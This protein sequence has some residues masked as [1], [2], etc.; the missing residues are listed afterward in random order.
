MSK[1]RLEGKVAIITGAAS[2]IG[3]ATARLFAENG[4]FVVIADIQDELGQSV[5]ASI[6][7]DKS[8]YRHCDVRDENQVEETVTF[9]LGK[10]G[11][12]DVLFSNAGIIGPPTSILDMNL[13][14]LDNTIAVNVRGVAATIK[15]VAR[16]M[17]QHKTR[18][19]II[20]TMSV[21]ANVGGTGPHAYSTS[22]SA[23]IGL[24]RSTASELGKDGI[25]VNGVSPHGVA[26]PLSCGVS[27]VEPS[28]LEA[29]CCSTSC[30]KGVVLKTGHVAEAVLFLASDESLFIS[31]HNLAVDG[32]FS[33]VNSSFVLYK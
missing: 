11:R 14:E 7:L 6:G 17:V 18:G 8:S 31:G 30:L 15:H 4:A 20:C 22:K 1:P 9:T 33:V 21:A 13:E 25:R 2:G 5:A 12:I 32:G 10:Y 19:S 26:T 23:L 3:E 16:A 28:H 29:I 27:G 24:V